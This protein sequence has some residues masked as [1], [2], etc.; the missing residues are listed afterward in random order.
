MKKAI[1][2]GYE[3]ARNESKITVE[4]RVLRSV[5]THIFRESSSL[6]LFLSPSLRAHP[7][8]IIVRTQGG[9]KNSSSF[10]N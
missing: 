3:K 10:L 6:S 9:N 4:R 1:K 7:S 8:Y 5:F 2:R